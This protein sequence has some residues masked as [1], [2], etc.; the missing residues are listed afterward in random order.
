MFKDDESESDAKTN[1][2]HQVCLLSVGSPLLAWRI[3]AQSPLLAHCVHTHTH[4]HTHKC[5]HAYIYSI[6][7]RKGSI[8][9]CC[10][11][12]SFSKVCPQVYFSVVSENI[13]LFEK[14]V[15]WKIFK[16]SMPKKKDFIDFC[17]QMFPSLKTFVSSHKWFFVVFPKMLL[18]L[19]I[20]LLIKYPV[21]NP[22]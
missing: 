19:K 15:K 16:T 6:F 11:T 1:S 14:I 9:F 21:P 18:F 20:Y 5:A 2:R 7:H 4:T 8:Y 13:V 3:H 22:R 10:L 17:R 12:H